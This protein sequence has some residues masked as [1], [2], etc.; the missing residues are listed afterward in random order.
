M[1]PKKTFYIFPKIKPLP[2]IS[3]S[4]GLLF[5]MYKLLA[6]SFL[7]H[8]AHTRKVRIQG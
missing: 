3:C 6:C 4:N 2:Q 1:V 7:I 8:S 5:Y